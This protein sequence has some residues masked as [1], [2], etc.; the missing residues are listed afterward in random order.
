[1]S[2]ILELRSDS[3]TSRF[4]SPG[5]PKMRS[6]P[7]LSKAAT[8]KSEPLVIGMSSC[9]LNYT[10]CS[11]ETVFGN[12]ATCSQAATRLVIACE[13][14]KRRSFPTQVRRP[15]AVFPKNLF[16]GLAYPIDAPRMTNMV[17]HQAGGE[18]QCQRISNTLAGN[19]RCRSM[20]GFE[21]LS[22]LANIG[23][24]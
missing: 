5:T 18:Q 19:A 21:D 22:G 11:S 24:G 20:D 9:R 7:S 1:M 17:Q 23:A 3:T 2:L 16:D 14:S 4:S 12:G 13:N 10:I 15:H 6:T 8:S